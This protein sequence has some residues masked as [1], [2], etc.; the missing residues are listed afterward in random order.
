MLRPGARRLGGCERAEHPTNAVLQR[1]SLESHSTSP[2]SLAP[3][4]VS[5]GARRWKRQ[6]VSPLWRGR[7][8]Y[9][10]ERRRVGIRSRAVVYS[11]R[12]LVERLVALR[13]VFRLLFP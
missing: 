5:E 8:S 7:A 11:Y 6:S 2:F 13:A 9:R 12:G 3:G 1:R 4:R 10:T